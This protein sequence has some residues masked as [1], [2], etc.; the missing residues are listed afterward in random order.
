[1]V[2]P[3]WSDFLFTVNTVVPLMLLML[4]GLIARQVHVIAAEGVKQANSAVFHIFLPILLCINVMDT[5]VATIQDSWVLVYAMA[6]ILITFLVLIV[7]TPAICASP[8]QRGVFIQGV[9]RSNYAI[10][11]IPLVLMMYPNA[12]TSI[13]AL[14]VVAVVP[15]FNVLSTL[16]LML[17]SGKKADFG[18]IFRGILTNPLIIGTLIGFALWQ[19]G[20][21]FPAMLDKPLRSLGS[22]ATPLAL[23]L[24]GASI[25]FSKVRASARLLTLGVLG[26]LLLLPLLFLS[27]AILLGARD[28]NLATLIAVF[29]SPTAVSSYPMAQQIGGDAEYAAAQIALTTAFSGITVFLW[30]FAFKLLGVVA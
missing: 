21:H 25:D 17:N 26:R 14:M 13:S 24:L 10:Y 30:I 5:Q 3:V 6:A 22:I 18:S 19:L 23:F 15:L 11:G 2:C 27:I 1:M 16:V 8:L 20:W 4:A 12:D 29:A 9:A 7:L 28:V